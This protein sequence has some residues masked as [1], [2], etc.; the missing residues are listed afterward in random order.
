MRTAK[1]IFFASAALFFLS[2]LAWPKF[3]VLKTHAR[4]KIYHPPAFHAK[5]RQIPL[6]VGSVDMRTGFMM[7][8]RIQ[9]FL[10]EALV[11]QNFKVT[12]GARTVIECTLTDATASLETVSRSES[13]NVHL[14]EHTEEKNGKKKQVED[15]KNQTVPVTYLISSGHLAMEVKAK[16][17]RP[18]TLLMSPMVE[19][20]YRQESAIAGPPKCGGE[21]YRIQ[22]SQLQDPYSILGELGDE[23]IEDTLSLAA[24]FAHGLRN[25]RQYPVLAEHAPDRLNV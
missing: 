14:G 23:A 8:P 10:E 20:V 9:H 18:Q 19:R 22:R 7:V 4:F 1:L 12:P 5:G 6:E 11:G 13:V 21:T 17:T 15:C 2:A 25:V 16:D 3:G 24:A